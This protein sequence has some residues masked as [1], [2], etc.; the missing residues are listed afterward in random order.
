[1]WLMNKTGNSKTLVSRPR[2]AAASI[3]GIAVMTAV[4]AVK[5]YAP[6]RSAPAPGFAFKR[7][8]PD[9]MPGGN[10][11]ALFGSTE[12]RYADYTPAVEAYLKRAYPANDVPWE[13]TLA[14]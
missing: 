8:V 5:T 4:V 3:L 2:L 13:A 9:L 14:A 12:F 7:G 6:A 11:K 1:M 10:K